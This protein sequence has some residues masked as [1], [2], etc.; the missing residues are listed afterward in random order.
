MNI[1]LK[2]Q[3][4]LK[5]RLRDLLQDKLDQLND[6]RP[7]SPI[8]LQKLKEKFQVEMTYNSNGI[9]G[10]TLSLNETYWV[11]QEGITVKGKSLKEH[12]EVKDHKKA[13]EKLYDLIENPSELDFTEKLV[14]DMHQTVVNMSEEEDDYEYRKTDVFIAGSDHK[15]SAPDQIKKEM[16]QLLRWS[17]DHADDYHFIEFAALFHHRFAQIHPFLDGNGRTARLLMNLLLMR[18]GYPLV[19]ILKNDRQ[20]YYRA[21]RLADSGRQKALTQL[22][23]QSALRSLNMYLDTITPAKQKDEFISLSEATKFCSYSQEYLSKLAKEGRL[24]AHK[25]SRNWVTT[26]KAVEEYVTRFGKSK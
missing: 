16:Q 12:L 22:I 23:A 21:L 13:L 18:E 26:K 15:P 9:E 20:K 24:D 11:F 19:I 17:R 10:N 8:M 25:K 1:S 14:K 4:Q 5:P 2:K 3:D 7:I 6:L